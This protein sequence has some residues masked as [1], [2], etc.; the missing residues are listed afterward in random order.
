MDWKNTFYPLAI[1]T[2][3]ELS[4]LI[5]SYLLS[6]GL[7]TVVGSNKKSYLQGQITCDILSL[8]DSES[9]LG[10]YCNAKGKVWSVF[11]L[12]YHNDGYAMFQPI[13]A[14]ETTL[15]EMRKYSIFYKL[16]I[17]QST[18]VA[19]GVIGKQAQ[20]FI[21]SISQDR[22]S[23]RMI[24]GGTGIK[25]DDERWLLLLDEASASSLLSGTNCVKATESIWTRFDIES[26]LP[27]IKK[28]QQNTY[29]PQEINLDLLNGISFTKGCYAGQEAIA[30][31]KYRG[32]NKRA[33]FIVRGTTERPLS[34]QRDTTLDRAVG[35][36]WRNA[37]QL[38][39]SYQFADNHAIGLLVTSKKLEENNKFRLTEQPNHIWH[40]TPSP[41]Y[42]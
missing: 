33:M 24:K 16:Q 38:L 22:T 32:V 27:I 23:V 39:E 40:I 17:K 36:N 31:A 21:D 6:W 2:K 3:S 19:L 26:G 8:K 29:T 12:F 9:T 11:R 20:E 1:T 18:D 14:I 4:P 34:K 30:K 37:G 25:I 28:N 5:V 13:S 35:K 42:T 41:Y 10:A 15:K 7:V